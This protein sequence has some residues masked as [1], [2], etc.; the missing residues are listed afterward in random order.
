M[1]L[2][3]LVCRHR[4]GMVATEALHLIQGDCFDAVSPDS[5]ES[6]L[7]NVAKWSKLQGL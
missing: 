3:T 5:S 7:C 6:S 4:T 2:A 1:S